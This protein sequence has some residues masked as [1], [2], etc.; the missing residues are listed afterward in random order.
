MEKLH[1]P[2]VFVVLS[3]P[4]WL[5]SNPEGRK[6]CCLD[7]KVFNHFSSLLEQIDRKMMVD[8]SKLLE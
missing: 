2:F 3:F 6:H 4:T 1:V 8:L 5:V 7:Y